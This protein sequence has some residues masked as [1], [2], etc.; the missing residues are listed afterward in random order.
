ML[1]LDGSQG[2]GGGQILRSAL[3]LSLVT[4]TPFRIDNIRAGRPR[5]GLMRQHLT[6][7]EA[8][9]AIGQAEVSG[10]AVGARS[11]FFR[12]GPVRGGEHR[13][14]VGTAGSATLVLQTVLPAL[15]IAA[16]PTT[17]VLEGGTHN[18][19]SPPFDFLA[20][21]FLP[22]VARMGPRVEATL[23]RPGFYPAG[24]GRLRVTVSP[25]ARLRPLELE[26]RGPI[27]AQRARVLLS[28]LPRSIGER[29]IHQLR[30]RFGWE[31]RAFA[32]E[33]VESAGPGNVVLIEVESG[34]L[35][36]VFVGFG[37]KGVRAEAVAERAADEAAAYLAAEVP[38]GPHL[39]DQLVLPLAL[40]G[41]GSFRTLAPTP[42]LRTQVAVVERFLEVK[43]ELAPQGEAWRFHV[44]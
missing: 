21:A 19:A 18:P 4:G 43:M 1:V 16:E 20:R 39:A 42:H 2:E 9:A 5:P 12:P 14:S 41:G 31:A 11:V 33:M 15:L 7:V 10:A 26:E 25:V 22:L 34:S 3:G 35:T 27:L 17:L 32:I 29:E 13:F 24:G 40:A 6:A 30:Q 28:N 38:V 36:E 44:R 37:E 23:E 8:A